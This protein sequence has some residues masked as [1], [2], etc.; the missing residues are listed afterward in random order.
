MAGRRSSDEV[1]RPPRFHGGRGISAF[2]FSYYQYEEERGDLFRHLSDLTW[3]RLSHNV[4]T[5][6][7][8]RIFSD[9]LYKFLVAM[10]KDPGKID[11]L[12]GTLY[13]KNEWHRQRPRRDLSARELHL[14]KEKLDDSDHKL[15]GGAYHAICFPLPLILPGPL[16]QPHLFHPNNE[17]KE[18]GKFFDD[19][20]VC[21]E[22]FELC[23]IDPPLFSQTSRLP[24]FHRRHYLITEKHPPDEYA[25]CYSLIQHRPDVDLRYKPQE[26]RQFWGRQVT[27]H[28]QIDVKRNVAFWVISGED[29][30]SEIKDLFEMA[31]DRGNRLNDAHG[32]FSMNIEF[33]DLLLQDW[34]WYSS[35]IESRLK[36]SM[37]EIS[38]SYTLSEL[39]LDIQWSLAILKA[40]KEVVINTYALLTEIFSAQLKEAYDPSGGRVD[41]RTPEDSNP[42][43]KEIRAIFDGI[44]RNCAKVE[45]FQTR[46]R[47]L[48]ENARL[49]QSDVMVHRTGNQLKLG[50]L[51]QNLMSSTVI[52]VFL[53]LPGIFASTLFSTDI[54]RINGNGDAVFSSV[55][56]VRWLAVALPLTAMSLIFLYVVFNLPT[57]QSPQR[58]RSW[59]GALF[60]R[61][62]GGETGRE[63]RR[64]GKRREE[65]RNVYV[66]PP[67]GQATP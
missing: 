53:V 49:L 6:L 55:A 19:L 8:L 12:S 9:S 47:Q 1:R 34:R 40:N 37:E 64:K 27:V 22:F 38:D 5:P 10:L 36:D 56:L 11:I 44:D 51:S 62:K 58:F 20:G 17:I 28:Q 65:E 63:E 16:P 48:M 14:W 29:P 24:E 61:L 33:F 35:W 50:L 54:V 42:F 4:Y 45:A 7:S 2:E 52:A 21:L 31:L 60:L 3:I 66:L 46:T 26:L 39:V 67:Y 25:F 23:C 32:I 41:S 57:A 59:L 18:L 43:S 13:T 30:N 15:T